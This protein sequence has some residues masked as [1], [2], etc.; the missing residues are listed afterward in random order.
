MMELHALTPYDL[1]LSMGLCVAVC[2]HDANVKGRDPLLC[3]PITR[4]E[5][6]A[7]G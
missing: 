5:K 1:R 2:V 4:A 6:C 3:L 7:T